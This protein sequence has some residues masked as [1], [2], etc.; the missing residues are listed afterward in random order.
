MLKVIELIQQV[1]LR[2]NWMIL[3]LYKS[4]YIMRN[5]RDIKVRILFISDYP[6]KFI[7]EDRELLMRMMMMGGNPMAMLVGPSEDEIAL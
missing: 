6:E 1:R 4:L 2:R 5:R 7:I 3:E